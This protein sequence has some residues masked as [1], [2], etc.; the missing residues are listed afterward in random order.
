MDWYQLV[1]TTN[2]PLWLISLLTLFAVGIPFFVLFILGLKMLINNLKSIGM[3]AKIALFVIW[4]AAVVGLAIFGVR[5]ATET[6]FEG[7]FITEYILPVSSGDTLTIQMVSNELYE[8]DARRRGRLDIEYNENDEKIIYSTDVRLIVR[9]TNDSV[10]RIVIEK[11]ADGSDYLSAKE[12]AGAIDYSYTYDGSVLGLNAYFTTPLENNYRDQ[13]VELIV[14]LPVG[15]ILYAS[16]NTFSFH[17]ND[18]HYRD[19]LDNGD[20]EHYLLIQDGETRCLDCPAG[21]KEVWEED[22][23][24]DWNDDDEAIKDNIESDS[25]IVN[26]EETIIDSTNIEDTLKIETE[27]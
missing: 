3:P 18:Y 10:A 15:T 11:R 5:Q 1:D 14:Y 25:I 2:A 4:I 26:T 27:N 12:R 22:W 8:Y 16:D 20:E 9:S 24:N 13:E 6:A 23:E 7:E 19:I 21:E 17:R